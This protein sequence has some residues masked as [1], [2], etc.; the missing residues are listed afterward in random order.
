VLRGGHATGTVI[1]SGG[2]ELVSSGGI[3]AAGRISGGT[4][5]V[6]AGGTASGVVFSS[7]GVLKL[8]SG[9]LPI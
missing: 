8:D 5:E 2:Y 3:A 4:L 6:A 7:G 1:S 9:A